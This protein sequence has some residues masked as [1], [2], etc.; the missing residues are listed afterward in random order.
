MYCSIIYSMFSVP[1]V[2]C[3]SPNGCC[4]RK[5]WADK[6]FSFIPVMNQS[7][8]LKNVFNQ[9]QQW[10]SVMHL[11]T[12]A[13][14]ES[15]STIFVLVAPLTD[16]HCHFRYRPWYCCNKQFWLLQSKQCWMS[17]SDLGLVSLGPPPF[18]SSWVKRYCTFVKEQK[19]LHMVTFDHRSG[20]KIVSSYRTHGAAGH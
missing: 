1:T 12:F 7:C 9:Q 17:L 11:Q 6:K 15:K 4:G 18:G 5:V 2:D 20:G 14:I 8:R 10:C 16:T 19:I 13:E 3:H